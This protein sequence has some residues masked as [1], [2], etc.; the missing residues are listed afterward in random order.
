MSESPFRG[1]ARETLAAGY[2]MLDP[3]EARRAIEKDAQKYVD[4]LAAYRTGFL[5]R[6][7][8]SLTEELVAVLM[9]DWA[10]SRRN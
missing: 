5:R 1:L 2:R 4:E 7:P 9:A 6:G 3:E 8:G 10:A